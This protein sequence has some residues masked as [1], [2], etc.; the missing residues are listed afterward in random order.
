MRV[1]A[2]ALRSEEEDG[3]SR[4]LRDVFCQLS[5]GE[6]LGEPTRLVLSF[7]GEPRR[8]GEFSLCVSEGRRICQ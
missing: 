5:T 8:V 2:D 7:S 1:L 6:F 3:H 4:F